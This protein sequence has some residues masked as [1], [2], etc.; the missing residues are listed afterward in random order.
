MPGIADQYRI[1]AGAAGWRRVN[2][3]GF[4]RLEGRDRLSFLQ[5]LVTNDVAAL[6]PGQGA[7]AAWLTP[8]GRM[9]SDLR[10]YARPAEMLAAVP[11]TGAAALATSLD[12]LVFSE[13]VTIA[14]VS[15]Q[16]NTIAVVG[17]QASAAVATI[18]GA[19]T[20]TLDALPLWSQLDFDAGFVVRTDDAKLPSYEVCFASARES[21]VAAR[22]AA[23]RAVEMS[24]ELATA[25]RVDAGRPLFGVDMDNETIPLEAGL[26]DRAISTTKGCYVG[27]EVIIRVLH[28]GGGRVAR[29]LVG[30]V[31][32]K[33]DSPQ[34]LAGSTLRVSGADVGRVTSA[35][36]ALDGN[37]V[38]ALGYV[39]REHAEPG[40]E[41]ATSSV[42]PAAGLIDSV[43]G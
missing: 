17:G 13:D 42:T 24:D 28:R 41:I 15:D 19:E 43:V 14:D 5:A 25:L 31:F 34:S 30:L 39:K 37:G 12:L 8:Q 22:L 35:A 1:I 11:A 2:E 27:Q 21:D 10:L 33:L 23:S 16:M 29:R 7:Y 4:L 32:P 3:R 26:L 6:A 9:I 18:C 36:H 40:V 20:P 38:I